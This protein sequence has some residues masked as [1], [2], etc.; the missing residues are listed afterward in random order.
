MT[1]KS[2]EEIVRDMLAKIGA[3][4]PLSNFNPGSVIRTLVE[5]IAFA[6]A[7]LY[8]LVAAVIKQGF[9]A[10]ATGFWLDLKVREYGLTRKPAIMTRGMVTFGRRRALGT[11]VT[12]P[13]GVIVTTLT[14]QNGR[15]FRFVTTEAV[16]LQSGQAE[17]LVPVQAEK[18]GAAWN[19]GAGAIQKL[20]VY[21]SGIDYVRNDGGWIT[22]EGADTETD[23]ELRRRGFL[24][25][26]ELARGGT[27]DAYISW[28]LS[29]PGVKNAF[30]DDTLPRG[31]GTVDVYVISTAGL[32][33]AAL[34]AQV[35]GVVDANRPITADVLVKAPTVR[36]I[37]LD[38][39][40]TP[41][42]LADT[43]VIES[44]LRTRMDAFFN[45][46]GDPS[47]DLPTFNW[48]GPLGIGRDVVLNQLTH[49]AMSVPGV[50]DVTFNAPTGDIVIAPYEFPVLQSLGVSFAPATQEVS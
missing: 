44:E 5:V 8:G 19:V 6:I 10:T 33:T 45:P 20:T 46:S 39:V 49:I 35:Q 40:V 31:Q 48:N 22:A 4:S 17:V 41:K 38:L 21:V 2:F 13:A 32:P 27:R 29:V 18:S 12:I 11:N 25:W 36:W 14:D 9:L 37:A 23:E 34:V 30:V 26:A 42:R 28:A 1:I 7:E 24:A 47:F 3:R 50:Y 16:V 15:Q 43:T